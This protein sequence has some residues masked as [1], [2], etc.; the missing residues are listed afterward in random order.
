MPFGTR[1][2]IGQRHSPFRRCRRGDTIF[3]LQ[4]PTSHWSAVSHHKYSHPPHATSYLLVLK[5]SGRT[6]PFCSHAPPLVLHICYTSFTVKKTHHGVCYVTLVYYI[7][8]LAPNLTVPKTSIPSS[9]VGIQTRL[10]PKSSVVI[11]EYLYP[12]P[13]CNA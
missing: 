4:S 12:I 11:S 3:S 7:R 8:N 6:L 9:S 10:Y 2:L 5:Y 1:Y 13:A